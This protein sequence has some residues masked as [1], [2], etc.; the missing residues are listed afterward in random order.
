MPGPSWRRR[1]CR[2]R[3]SA[4]PARRRRRGRG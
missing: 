3:A 1:C 4:G 2:W